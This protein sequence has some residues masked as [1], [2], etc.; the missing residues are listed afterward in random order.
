MIAVVAFLFCSNP[1]VD[2]QFHLV[3]EDREI[4]TLY[5]CDDHAS[6]RWRHERSH[7]LLFLP[8][9]ATIGGGAGYWIPGP[10]V[11]ITMDSAA[12]SAGDEWSASTVYQD[13]LRYRCLEANELPT[14]F[15]TMVASLALGSEN[16]RFVQ[17]SRDGG[18]TWDDEAFVRFSGV[19][20]R[21]RA[22]GVVARENRY[23]AVLGGQ[24]TANNE[25]SSAI[26][27]QFE[28]RFP[29]SMTSSD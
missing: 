24:P 13:E 19:E 29:E 8:T 20:G 2:L 25:A 21:L 26:Y 12:C 1:E 27:I 15:R 9:A 17:E 11:A 7:G 18:V 5:V 10:R 6:V 23:G 3:F 22:A 28:P 16:D 14:E 4:A